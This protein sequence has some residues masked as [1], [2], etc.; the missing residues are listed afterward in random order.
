M[1]KDVTTQHVIQQNLP[2]IYHR[3]SALLDSSLRWN[4]DEG[5]KKSVT[6][7]T[8]PC[9]TRQMPGRSPF[10]IY[11]HAYRDAGEPALE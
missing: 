3:V 5:R 8:A 4:D 11:G 6:I 1:T 7:P 9:H 2:S 10:V